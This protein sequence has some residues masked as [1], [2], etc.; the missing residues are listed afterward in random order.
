MKELSLNILDIAQNSIKAGAKTIAV[1]LNENLLTDRLT[2]EIT[3][4]GCGMDEATAARVCDPFYT[5]RTTRK[6]GLGLPFLKMQAELTGGGME[7]RSVLGAGTTV[8][9][10]FV[11]S[12][13][14]FTPLGDL[15]STVLTLVQGS[16]SLDFEYLHIVTDS[17][18]TREK[19]F[20]TAEVREAL[21]GD[22][23]LAEP[24]VLEW[25]GGYLTELYT[26]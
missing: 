18:G 15:P 22:V 23:S 26:Q 20:F 2:L 5:S 25:I 8:K 19:R 3:D 12:S 4:D 7:L 1:T 10:W 14:D 16:P 6:V 24:E 17:A 13:V 9:A 21:G 11:P